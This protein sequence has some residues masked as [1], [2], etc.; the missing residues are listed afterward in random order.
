MKTRAEFKETVKHFFNCKIISIIQWAKQ[1]SGGKRSS[2]WLFMM[3]LTVTGALWHLTGLVLIPLDV[4]NKYNH[5]LTSCDRS[6]LHCCWSTHQEVNTKHQTL[7]TLP[8]I[9]STLSMSFGPSF[10]AFV[11]SQSAWVGWSDKPSLSLVN[12]E[13]LDR[14]DCRPGFVVMESGAEQRPGV[15]WRAV[16]SSQPAQPIIFQWY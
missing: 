14:T 7:L 4:K 8:A 11:K 1:T 5:R 6:R 12:P 3:W 10:T 2:G 9:H 13:C 15:I 16:R